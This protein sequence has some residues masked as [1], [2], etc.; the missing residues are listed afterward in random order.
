MRQSPQASLHLRCRAGAPPLRGSLRRW[1]QGTA[2]ALVLSLSAPAW[3]EIWGYVDRHGESHFADH[4]VDRRYELFYR[5]GQRP[6]KNSSSITP[7]AAYAPWLQARFAVST[8]YKA[9]RHLIREAATAYGLEYELLKAVIA[10]E[11]GFNARAVS[12][13]GAVGLMQLMPDTAKRFGVKPSRTETLQ[14]RLIDPRTNILAGAS[15]LSW[16]LKHFDGNTELALAAYNAGEGAVLRAG[17]RIP[18]YRETRDYVRK[19]TQL[20]QNLLPP[21][22]LLRQRTATTSTA[23]APSQDPLKT[24]QL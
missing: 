3:A 2:M 22:A 7:G 13:K 4:Q 24:A 8:S 23:N 5:G 6:G 20:H 16:L 14:E 17:R 9:V 18:N 1:L 21:R 19:V 15:Y 12:P 11:S 10:T